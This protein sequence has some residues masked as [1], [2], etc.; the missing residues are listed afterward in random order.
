M[1]LVIPWSELLALIAPHAPLGRTGRPPFATEVVLRITCCNN[2]SI[3]AIR[4]WKKRCT[5]SRCTGSLPGSILAS[6]AQGRHGGR[7][8]V[9][10]GTEP[11][12]ERQRATRPQGAPNQEGRSMKLW[13]GGSHWRGRRFGPGAHR[14]DHISPCTRHHPGGCAAARARTTGLCGLALPGRSQTRGGSGATPTSQRAHC[15][16]PGPAPS[17]GQESTHQRAQ[18][19]NWS[20]SRPASAPRSST[21]FGSSSASSGIARFAIAAW[22]RTPASCW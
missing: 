4:P 3:T 21:R 18:G 20:R 12:Q 13:H 16:D 10:C 6:R 9:D 15:H 14:H 19:A 11:D 1:S 8:H 7:C 5:T 22:L 2:S 17:D